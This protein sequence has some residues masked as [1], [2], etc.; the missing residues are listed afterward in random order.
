M[1]PMILIIS[2][3]TCLSV[4]KTSSLMLS[5]YL[6]LQAAK[7]E[8]ASSSA[9]IVSFRSEKAGAHR[10]QRS[11]SLEDTGSSRPIASPIKSGSQSVNKKRSKKT[12]AKK[13]AQ[14]AAR[15]VIF[16][17]VRINRFHCRGTYQVSAANLLKI[18][19]FSEEALPPQNGSRSAQS[20]CL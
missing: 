14:A 11:L 15:S 18:I 20:A 5:Q 1:N 6:C 3:L 16:V 19:W 2:I 10:H 4:L 12:S 7:C 13:G 17:H 8:E 9:N